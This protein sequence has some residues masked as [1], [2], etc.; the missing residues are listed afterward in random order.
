ML[1]KIKVAFF[2]IVLV[3][4]SAFAQQ[5]ESFTVNGLKVILKQN[6]SNDIIAVNLVFKGGTTILEPNQ[7]GIEALALNVALK[8]SEN[9]PKDRLNA[10]LESMAT[11]LGASSNLDYSSINML[12]VKQNF[13]KS[14]DIFS[15]IVLNPSFTQEDFR[16]EREQFL[17]GAKQASD[18]ADSYLQKLFRNAFYGDH[19][20]SI[21]VNGTENSLQSFN[22]EQLK[23]FFTGRKTTSQMFL[24]VVGNT[25]RGELE[26]M[27]AEAF[28]SLLKG[29]FN[30]QMP[31]ATSFSEPSIKVVHRELPTNYIQ[32][33]FSAPVRTTDEGYTM[34]ITRSILR[35]R[36][37]EEVRT[38]RSLSYAPTSRYGN[39][40]SNYAAIYVTAVDADSTIK[41]M[42]A[43]LQRLKDEPIPK[44]ELENKKRQFITFY[45]LGNE[46]NQNQAGV[47]TRFELSSAGYE[48]MDRFIDK[49]MKVTP[50]DI[51]S[52]ANKYMNNLQFVLIGNPE[53]LEVKNFMY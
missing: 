24:V 30:M 20:Y 34:N 40:L 1:K 52:V 10:E 8:A 43:E 50:E 13:E 2:L 39:L 19:P 18:N 3:T 26:P 25:S 35:D 45:Y 22:A 51:Q 41:V 28:G 32:G 53:S 6:T 17:S 4:A 16:L 14:W 47:L 42:I 12:C 49:L 29:N 46:T 27:V 37:W 15:D 33:S 38:K 48:E 11:Q 5:A 7:A 44:S 23:E 9:Y 21:E 31:P 36:V